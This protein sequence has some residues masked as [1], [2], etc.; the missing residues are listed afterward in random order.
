MFVPCSPRE[1]AA[2]PKMDIAGEEIGCHDIAERFEQ[3]AVTY[4]VMF[5]RLMFTNKWTHPR[6]V[7]LAQ[8]ATGGVSWLHS[9]QIASLR[10][11]QLKSPGPR[12]FAALVYL[13]NAIDEWQRG[14]KTKDSPDWTGQEE[15]I[16]DREVIRDEEGRVASIGWHFEVFCGWRIPPA[17]ATERNFTDEQAAEISANAAKH[18]RRRMIA[19]R[20][21]LID[22]MPKLQRHFSLDKD[23]QVL[24]RDVILGQAHWQNEQIDD[25]MVR[26]GNMLQKVFK[27]DWKPQELLHE[28][29]K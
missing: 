4:S 3:G 7:K 26:M 29:M 9:S 28:L 13:F 12:S 20:L 15:F 14:I 22:D 1:K 16:K 2:V 5:E 24:F 8:T 25:S 23:D 17:K 10:K 6:F 19:D 11:G 18:I 27:E 21:D